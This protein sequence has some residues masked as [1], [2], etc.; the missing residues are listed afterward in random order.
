MKP[1]D[2]CAEQ[3]CA[4]LPEAF[5][6]SPEMMERVARENQ[7][8]EKPLCQLL[9]EQDVI[10]AEDLASLFITNCVED[11]GCGK[12]MTP[13]SAS[14]FATLAQTLSRSVVKR[15]GRVTDGLPALELE[16]EE[17]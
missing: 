17:G 16:V 2:C 1:H 14:V 3:I 5:G 4:I 12:K 8:T 9:M 15:C 11:A 6:I 13:Q 10:S 7:G